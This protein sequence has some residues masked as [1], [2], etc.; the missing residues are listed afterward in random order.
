ME[1]VG[2]R[3]GLEIHQEL[4]GGKLFCGCGSELDDGPPKMIVRR[5]LR[6]TQSEL[7]EVDRAALA[8]ALKGKGFRYEVTKNSCLVEMDCEPPHPVNEKALDAAL[9]ISLLLNAKP[10]EEIHVMRKI[11]I[12]GSNTTGFQRTMLVATDGW[13]EVDGKKYS[14]KTICLEEDAARKMGEDENEVTYRLD[15]L[16]IPLVEIAT[17]AEFSDPETPAKVALYIGQLMR[18][19]GKVKRGIGTIRQDINISIAGGARQEIKGIQELELIPEVIRREVQRQKALLEIREEL[20]RRGAVAVKENF[21]DVTKVFSTTGSQIIKRAVAN[22]G[23]VLAVVLPRFGGLL[24]KEVQPGRR[25]GTELADVARVYGKVGGIFHTDELPGCGIGLREV[26]EMRRAVGAE[27]DDAVVLVADR[28]EKAELALRKVVER[29]N[30]ALEGVPEETR[31]ALPDGNTEFMRPLPGAA[32]MYPET[33]I[34]PVLVEAGRL[35]KIRRALAEPPE[36]TVERLR[37]MGL[38]QHLAEK[39]VFSGNAELLETLVEKSGADPTLAA[40]TIEE[41]LVSLRREGVEVEKIAAEHLAEVLSMVMRGGI[42]KEA[43]PEV[44]RVLP[45][46]GKVEEAVKRL[47]LSAMGIDELERIVAEEIEKNADVVM[48]KK[49]EAVGALMGAVMERV[50]GRIDGKTVHEIVKR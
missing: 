5:R 1:D 43:V 47:G 27:A 30:M 44:L 14:I 34:P 36:V 12:D 39:V 50:R 4:S 31:R 45:E 23:V 20:K 38:S 17:G 29:A 15:R 3:V 22:G 37:R 28:R 25:F 33:D 41:T 46:T 9:E 10:V 26:E 35:R 42:A 32:R 19:T 8:E 48:R 16:G 11:V 2:L 49:M 21:F 24:G 7:G 13:V 40:T 18:A 6:P